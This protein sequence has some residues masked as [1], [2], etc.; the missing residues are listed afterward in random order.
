MW[1]RS[2]SVRA[3]LSRWRLLVVGCVVGGV[4]AWALVRDD[5]RHY[6]VDAS[7]LL[8]P[9]PALDNSAY[10]DA[11]SAISRE[12]T[13]L[14]PTLLR[15]FNGERFERA[16]VAALEPGA[17]DEY[18]LRTTIR[19]GTDIIEIAITGPDRAVLER[20]SRT[21]TLL[22]AEWAQDTYRGAFVLDALDR[23]SPVEPVAPRV[24]HAVQVGVLLGA[25]AAALLALVA[26]VR[27]RR[28]PESAPHATSKR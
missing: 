25:G 26:A 1:R 19:P 23:T 20:I 3:L 12:Q 13:G 21:A 27:P 17:R 24:G 15:I 18:E 5:A 2:P 22:A 4:L 14:E 10:D 9:G 7:L 8:R 11:L 28:R 16:A 6:E